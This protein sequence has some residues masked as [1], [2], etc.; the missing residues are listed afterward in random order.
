[1]RGTK[2]S[3]RGD[4]GMA[5]RTL[6]GSLAA[7]GL[8]ALGACGGG[9]SATTAADSSSASSASSSGASSGGTA[10]ETTASPWIWARTGTSTTPKMPAL[11]DFVR[12]VASG[13]VNYA[14][15]AGIAS[16]TTDPVTGVVSDSSSG[17]M[18][19][20]YFMG[21]YLVTNA[22]WKAFMNAVGASYS[23][24][25]YWNDGSYPAGKEDHP[26]LFVSCNDAKAYCAW[27][28]T[29]I[30]GYV[31]YVPTEGEWEYAA[32][33]G[34]TT[35]SFPWGTAANLSFN[36]ST[37]VLGTVYNCN[38]LC[39]R[40]VL[41]DSGIQ[42]LTYYNDETV[43]TLSDG[44][45]PLTND[46]APLARVLSMNSSGGVTGWQYDST[47]NRTWADFAN[48]D[49]YDELVHRFGGYTTT[50]GS[51]AGGASWCGCL[52]MAGNAY[53]WTSTVNTASNGAESGTSV[54]CVKGGSWYSTSA[55]G[56]STGRGEGRAPGG[57]YHSVGFRVAA[58]AL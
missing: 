28:T 10:V 29:Q 7:V 43:T 47:T 22:N 6:L 36:S 45:T 30:P 13:T 12:V 31:F 46:T 25:S 38:A 3:E 33:G 41:A 26:V 15:H 19:V 56:K 14:F 21:K 54:N 39:T 49:T 37:G 27:L 11:A 55:S 20:P 52:D 42:T 57:A 24:G 35:Y 18:L 50:V 4:G 16:T 5:R 9:G 53:E 1:M 32:L 2:A 17:A 23:P 51:F 8:G 48:S 58:R 44:A 34:N 40:F